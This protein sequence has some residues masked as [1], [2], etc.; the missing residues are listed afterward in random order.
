MTKG[1]ILLLR[2]S[3]VSEIVKNTWN[4]VWD[5]ALNLAKFFLFVLELFD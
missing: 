4:R 3:T 1:E 2:E 5:P